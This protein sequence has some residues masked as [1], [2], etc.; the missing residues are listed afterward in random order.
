MKIDPVCG[1]EV[2]TDSPHR[3]EFDGHQW[4]FC[5]SHCH[6][7]FDANPDHFT[8]DPVC[9]MHVKPE[10]L[11]RT[12]HADNSYRFCSEKCLH[13]FEDDPFLYINKESQPDVPASENAMGRFTCP[14]HPEIEQDAPGSCPKCGMA[15]EPMGLPESS[16]KT[17]YVC[18][19]HP[20]VVCDKPGSC[21]KCGMALEPHTVAAEEE[22]PELDNMNRRF[23]VSV[24]LAAPV[25]ILAM[26]ADL[27]PGWLPAGLDIG[28]VQWIEFVLATPVVLWGGWPFFE[29]MALSVKTWNLNMFTLIGLGVGVAWIYS[30]VALLVPTVFP[31]V[32]QMEGGQVDVYFEAAAVIIALVLLGQ[33]LELRARSRTN[34]AIKLLLGMAPK[35]D[36]Y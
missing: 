27:V 25:F 21:P 6:E 8:I 19:M 17:E 31:P 34:E 15:L 28:T 12:K 2:K 11:H 18:P 1:M 22:N 5:S 16:G 33:V 4:H 30:V 20:E 13:K 10:S 23:N 7:K 26:V 35:T 14:M 24:V 29:R 36:H 9:S 3:T 32:M